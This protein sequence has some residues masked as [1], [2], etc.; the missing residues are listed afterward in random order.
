TRSR[1]VR[2]SLEKPEA[3]RRNSARAMRR[4][5]LRG[6]ARRPHARRTLCTLSVRSRAPTKQMGPYRR[7]S[8]ARLPPGLARDPFVLDADAPAFD[9]ET[10]R[11]DGRDDVLGVLCVPDDEIRP[12]A[13]VDAI[14]RH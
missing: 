2:A 9:D 13:D 4:V 1:I 14:V 12:A 8:L 5:Q 11:R 6:G 7:P 3:C 10:A